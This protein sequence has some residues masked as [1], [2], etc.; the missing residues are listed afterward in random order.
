MPEEE[1]SANE[2][3]NFCQSVR[4]FSADDMYAVLNLPG[5][6]GELCSLLAKARRDGRKF[7]HDQNIKKELGDIM[8]SVAIIALDNG[9]T[10]QDIIDGNVAKLSKRKVDGTLQGSGDNR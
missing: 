6:V 1:M 10:L 2:Y 8:W 3:Q 5:E 9:W 7:D 4:I